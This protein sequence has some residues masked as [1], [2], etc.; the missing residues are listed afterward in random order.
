MMSEPYR[1]ERNE[2]ADIECLIKRGACA[3]WTPKNL[4]SKLIMWACDW[5]VNNT[6]KRLFFAYA[7]PV[8]GEI[9]TI[10]QAC[11]FDYLGR[12]KK[13][14]YWENGKLKNAQTSK[15]TSRLLPWMKKNGISVDPA[16]LTKKGYLRWSAI[17]E[18][19]RKTLRKHVSDSSKNWFKQDLWHSKYV[20]FK[21]KSKSERIKLKAEYAFPTGPYPK[22]KF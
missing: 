15:R 7:D 18:V 19:L 4:G 14:V 10:Y 2:T 9:G 1:Y 3:S 20:L 12:F 16:W 22:R 8:A 17:P 11:G 21:S 13:I 5:M 6:Q